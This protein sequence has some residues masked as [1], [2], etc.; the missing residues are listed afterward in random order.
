MPPSSSETNCDV[1]EN[2]VT[3]LFTK[4]IGSKH[5]TPDEWMMSSS[6][7]LA[8]AIEGWEEY[9]GDLMPFA[10]FRSI[11]SLVEYEKDDLKIQTSPTCHG[12][13]HLVPSSPISARCHQ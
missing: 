2:D 1:L 3:E 5:V 8:N 10:T 11:E 9:V 12:V 4:S 13:P 7:S 6:T